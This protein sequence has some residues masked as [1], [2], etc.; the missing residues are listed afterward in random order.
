MD[1]RQYI[2][3]ILPLRLEWEPCYYLPETGISVSVK[4]G[5]RIKVR[6]A[7]KWYTGVVSQTDVTPDIDPSRIGPA[8]EL[9]TG[10]APV[11]PCE[12]EFWRFLSSYYLCTL[13]EVYKAA[14]PLPRLASEEV[15]LRAS[16]RKELLLEKEISIWQDRIHKL[17]TRLEAKVRALEG[18]HGAQVKA[19]L[20]EE[21]DR[22]AAELEKA[23]AHLASLGG[24]IF[25]DPEIS[26]T[27]LQTNTTDTLIT[28]ALKGNKPVL[29]KSSSRTGTYLEIIAAYLRE[30]KNALLLV[31][32]ISLAESLRK[33]LEDAF[34]DMLLVH[35]SDESAVRRRKISDH[36]RS[37]EPYVVLG[38]RSSIF[39]PFRD[40]G[41]VIIDG[42]QSSFY[43]QSDNSPRYNAR[44]AAIV[45][46]GI[47]GA[48]IMLGT[49]SP[50]LESLLYARNGRYC[51]I[52]RVLDKS[53]KKGMFLVVDIGAEK[54]KNGM[55]GCISRKLA[56]A[57]G[58]CLE[59]TPRGRIA[60]VR[61]F[62]KEDEAAA[63]LRSLFEG[64]EDRFD[65]YTIPEA[66]RSDLS[67]YQLIAML[68][69]DAIFRAGD[70][71]SDERAFQFLDKLRGECSN[72]IVQTGNAAQ[73]VFS[74]E[75]AEPLLTERRRFSLPPYT[76]L[77]DILLPDSG[78]FGKLHYCMSK[79]L[80]RQGFHATD[81][82]P[83]PDGKSLIR[84]TLQRDG[85][86]Q[87]R[88]K[89][90]Y[91]AVQAFRTEHHSNVIIDVDPI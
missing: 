75:S 46:G 54:K 42:E 48:G 23:R 71:R 87:A 35:H 67:G 64:G 53:D 69:A 90:L 18:R 39:L 83:L 62:E 61:G 3:V 7:N 59:A 25:N 47:H 84:V 88:K 15:Q 19:R 38:T 30:G 74:L 70:F 32:E 11:S 78:R 13:G 5:D 77:V 14:Y 28:S 10:L 73:Q 65:I 81:P 4:E 9:D 44:D 58:S 6:F 2:K 1:T 72:V 55:Y 52:D 50:S 89:A 20:R 41:I 49:S 51:L 21:K 37:G 85:M 12:M 79:E 43:K 76:R 40:L 33:E 45:L 17:E 66:Q 86:F 8:G 29:F 26:G 56:K 16:K 60:I 36:V 68:S 63:Q 27:T 57:I 31:P 80:A 82:I 91:A 22:I 24:N 34:G